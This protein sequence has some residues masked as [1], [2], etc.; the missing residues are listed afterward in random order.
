M[1]AWVSPAGSID[2][3]L[4][5]IPGGIESYSLSSDSD[6]IPSF[7]HLMNMIP[8]QKNGKYLSLTVLVQNRIKKPTPM[9][10]VGKAIMAVGTVAGSSIIRQGKEKWEPNLDLDL[11]NLGCVVGIPSVWVKLTHLSGKEV[12]DSTRFPEIK[13]TESSAVVLHPGDYAIFT[14]EFRCGGPNI[15]LDFQAM[16]LLHHLLIPAVPY[17]PTFKGCYR[18]LVPQAAERD[19]VCEIHAFIDRE[20]VDAWYKDYEIGG[21]EA[22]ITSHY[23]VARARMAR[24]QHDAL[25]E[26]LKVITGLYN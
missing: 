22:Y 6:A 3:R 2:C 20:A 14:V 19:E 21:E 7:E 12:K 15:T 11:P 4:A 23:G 13:D 26:H 24:S 8:G 16:R 5:T 17:D 1:G 18:E 10:V 25:K 9:V